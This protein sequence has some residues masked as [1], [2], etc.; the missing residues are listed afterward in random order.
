MS[1]SCL[2]C[3]RERLTW[4]QPLLNGCVS[5]PPKKTLPLQQSITSVDIAPTNNHTPANNNTPADT[6]NT[7]N[8]TATNKDK[9]ASTTFDILIRIMILISY[10]VDGM[11]LLLAVI[12]AHSTLVSYTLTIVS[13]VG[14]RYSGYRG[15]F[16]LSHAMHFI[17]F[18]IALPHLH[19]GK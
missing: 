3:V 19:L 9:V 5:L 8:D 16:Q 13:A 1:C 6:D 4:C 15:Y 17:S 14:T 2:V 18:L 11:V 7:N 10:L 12:K